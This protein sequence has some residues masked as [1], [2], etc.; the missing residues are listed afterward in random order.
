VQGPSSIP[1]TTKKKK[2]N[3]KTKYTHTPHIRVH[4]R[5][6]RINPKGLRMEHVNNKINKAVPAYK[7]KE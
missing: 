6:A 4:Q 7:P 5:N 2:I 1:R 3:P